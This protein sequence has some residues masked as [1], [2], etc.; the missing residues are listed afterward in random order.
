[1][2]EGLRR[3][4]QIRLFPMIRKWNRVIWLANYRKYR[5]IYYYYRLKVRLLKEERR[6]LL[7]DDLRGSLHCFAVNRCVD[8]YAGILAATPQRP[9]SGSAS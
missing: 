3:R 5:P 4:W 9:A 8:M 2:R 6:T 7:W 1:V